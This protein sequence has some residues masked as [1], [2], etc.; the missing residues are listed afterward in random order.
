[1]QA[2]NRQQRAGAWGP[3]TKRFVRV[4]SVTVKADANGTRPL[5]VMISGAP[6]AGKGTQCAKIVDKYGLVHISAGD[7][8]REQV[9]LGTDAGKR[10]KD[11]MDRGVLVPDDVIVDM[12]KDRLAQKDVAERGWLLDGYPR[13]ASQAEAIEKEGI[14]PDL[15]LLIEVPSELLVERVVGRRMDPETG[16]IY[17]LKYKPPP[18]EVVGRLVQRSDDTEEKCKT[19]LETHFKNVE[20][21]IGYYNAACVEV[22]GNR[23]MD[24][25]FASICTAIDAA[26]GKLSDPLE[27]FCNSNPGDLECKV[28]DE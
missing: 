25:V 26:K 15:F 28:F 20:A 21:V 16:A 17:H 11:F 4:R 6:A 13:S 5:R 7:L 22:D 24:A 14:R 27:E 1:M 19:R 2:L 3:A 10:A 23:S 8:L 18:Q 12:I 9:A